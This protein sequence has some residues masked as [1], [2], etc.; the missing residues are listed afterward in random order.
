MSNATLAFH[1]GEWCLSLPHRKSSLIT[2]INERFLE[3]KTTDK[4]QQSLAKTERIYQWKRSRKLPWSI[5]L[6]M[7]CYFLLH[8]KGF[9]MFN[10]SFQ[11]LVTVF[12]LIQ[13]LIFLVL[14]PFFCLQYK[15]FC[16]VQPMS[17]IKKSILYIIINIFV[18]DF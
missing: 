1:P 2:E 9:I 6:P 3:M 4:L 16:S 15:S 8:F 14:N 5:C 17:L 13:R 11:A 12:P 7:P 18:F 10:P